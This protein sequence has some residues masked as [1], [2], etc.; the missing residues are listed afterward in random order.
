MSED[1]R[2]ALVTGGVQGLGAAA[3]KALLNQG[4]KLAAAHLGAG[5]KAERFQQETGIPVFEWDVADYEACRQGVERVA[6]EVGPIDVLVNNAGVNKDVMFHK[7][8]LEDWQAVMRVDLASM[9]NMTRPVIN[10]MRERGFGRVINISSVNAQKGQAGQTN[11]CAAKA[12]VLGFTRALARECASKGIT[13]NAVAPGY[14]ATPMVDAV[15][16]KIMDQILEQVPL[17]RL[18]EP[19]EI[20]RCVAFLASE[21]AGFLTGMTLSANGGFY[22]H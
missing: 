20:G 8:S 9:F 16:D 18:A 3:A 6:K 11:Y 2:V 19:W 21:E 22:M 13:V 14:A 1:G 15:P 5:E 4:F 10:G 7:M 17:G 12:G